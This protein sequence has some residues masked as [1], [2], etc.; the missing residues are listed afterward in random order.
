MI[1]V[2]FHGIGEST[3]DLKDKIVRGRIAGGVAILW[4]TK[5]EHIIS[6]LRLGVDWAVGIMVSYNN[7]QLAIINVYMPYEK[8]ENVEECDS[9]LAFVKSFMEELPTTSVCIVGD[10]NS[11]ISNP[12]SLFS[13]MINNFCIENGLVLSSKAML[14]ESSF[15]YVSDAWHTTSWLDHCIC[16]TDAHNS[17][18]SA[19]IL[20]GITTTDHIPVSL[21]LNIDNIP[22]IS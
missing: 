17:I 15:T 6:E 1:N 12:Q 22:E 16:T 14:P 2:N 21:Q 20:Y 13:E 4:N 9:R 8:P 11:N 18:N 19:N 7:R 5:Y 10:M 3:T